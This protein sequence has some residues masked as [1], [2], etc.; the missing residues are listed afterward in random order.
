MNVFLTGASSGIGAAMARE[1]G[2]RGARLGLV[3]R[4]A[5]ALQ[6]LAAE[7]PGRCDCYP[8]DVTDHDALIAAAQDFEARCGGTDIVVANAGISTGILTEHQEDLV[9]FERVIATNLVAAAATFHPFIAPMRARQR[10]TLVGIASVAGIRGLPGSEA[11]SPSKAALINYCE[12]L[13]VGL[14]GTGVQV[15]TIAPGFIRT[16]MTAENPYR[17]PFLMEPEDFA[18]KA[19]DA[20]LRRK[21][22]VVIPWQMAIVAKVLRALPNWAFDRLL[23]GRARKPRRISR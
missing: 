8:L 4:R 3:A 1:F 18:R 17:M 2:R 10:G 14:H 19:V 16:P 20:M 7:M 6:Q 9:G 21:S 12:S 15:V 13:R 22:Y 23:A 5:S 11:Y